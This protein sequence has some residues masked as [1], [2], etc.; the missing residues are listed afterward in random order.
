MLLGKREKIVIGDIDIRNYAKYILKEGE[1]IERRELLGCLN[2]Q[3]RLKNK[4]ITIVQ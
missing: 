3:I 1:D 4:E 2:G